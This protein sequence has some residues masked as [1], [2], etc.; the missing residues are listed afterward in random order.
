MRS[1]RK[2][3][4]GGH[5]SWV[6]TSALALKGQVNSPRRTL[7][8]VFKM[9]ITITSSHRNWEDREAYLMFITIGRFLAYTRPSVGAY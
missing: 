9:G 1:W 4:S 6:E 2:A 5:E 8:S 3:P 7:V